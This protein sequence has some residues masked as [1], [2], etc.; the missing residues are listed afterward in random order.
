MKSKG[1]LLFRVL[2]LLIFILTQPLRTFGQID[3]NDPNRATFT[4]NGVP[5]SMI[6]VEGG[7]MDMGQL[8]IQTVQGFWI[9]ETKV[10]N[11]LCVALGV[12]ESLQARS[13]ELINNDE[14]PYYYFYDNNDGDDLF[15]KNVIINNLKTVTQCNFRLPTAIEWLYAARGGQ[16]SQFYSYSGSNDRNQVSINT[17]QD[18]KSKIPNELGIYGMTGLGELTSTVVKA[19]YPWA[20][21]DDGYTIDYRKNAQVVLG[22]GWNVLSSH[23]AFFDRGDGYFGYRFILDQIPNDAVFNNTSNE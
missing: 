1:S 7:D 9:M 19:I 4:I 22:E 5:F 10:T 6:Y 8:D 3:A 23:T 13:L 11:S 20:L 15:I 2:L 16:K 14:H 18:V 17:S 12:N 21:D